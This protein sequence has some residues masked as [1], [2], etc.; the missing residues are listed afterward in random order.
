M[1][2]MSIYNDAIMGAITG[3]VMGW[4]GENTESAADVAVTSTDIF[5]ATGEAW[6]YVIRGGDA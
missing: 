3:E 2:D 6:L 4:V 5:L 1:N